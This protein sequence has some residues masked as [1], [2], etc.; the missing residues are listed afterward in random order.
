MGPY[1]TL[2][3]TAVLTDDDG[4]DD[5]IGGSLVDPD[6]GASYGAF[7]TSASE[8]SYQLTLSWGALNA[9]DPI[10]FSSSASRRLQARFFDVAGHEAAQSVTVTLTCNGGPACDGSC[11]A[12]RCSDGQCTS[13]DGYP[14]SNQWGI[15]GGVCRDL[16]TNNDC[17]ACNATCGGTCALVSSE[18]VACTCQAG[19]CSAGT[20][21]VEQQCQTASD[22]TLQSLSSDTPNDGLATML[23]GGYQ[24][25]VC[26]FSESEADLFCRATGYT[27]GSLSTLP[28][29]SG[30]SGYS[31][32]CSGASLFMDCV[33]TY[34]SSCD[35]N[36]V[37]HCGPP[38]PPADFSCIDL[39]LGSATS[40]SSGS[41]S[42]L[43]NDYSSCAGSGPERIYR[44]RA[45]ATGYYTFDTYGSALDTVVT[46]LDG[47]CSGV[48]L[49]CDDD[50]YGSGDSYLVVSVTAG[51]DYVIV[52]DSKTTTGTSFSLR[53]AAY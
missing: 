48:S 14:D 11:G 52:V 39:D 37:V 44:W 43:T 50:G 49:G 13:S 2:I 51:L 29:Y 5:I 42:G 36:R 38:A 10:D 20:A 28:S 16:A 25:T 22:L 26:G 33:F 1:D 32:D 21:C 18:Y 19:D 8:G 35:D 12:A 27:E 15:C 3:L 31:V 46:V 40:T 17:G 34:F 6:S 9:V 24:Y 45:P 4:I 41:T 23:I 53:I 30:Y 7:Q 47:G